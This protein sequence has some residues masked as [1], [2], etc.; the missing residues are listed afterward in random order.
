MGGTKIAVGMID[1]DGTVLSR[2]CGRPREKLRIAMR[3]ER[4]E[5]TKSFFITVQPK[6]RR[7]LSANR[8][9]V[10]AVLYAGV[11]LASEKFFQGAAQSLSVVADGL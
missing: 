6:M 11:G 10:G 5:N 2:D 8:T 3:A 7:Q 9:A 4:Q 1:N